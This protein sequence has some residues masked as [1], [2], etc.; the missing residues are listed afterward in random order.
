MGKLADGTP[1]P[2]ELPQGA[3]VGIVELLDCVDERKAPRSAFTRGPI[4]WLFQGAR[5]FEFPLKVSG[6]L[7]LWTEPTGRIVCDDVRQSSSVEAVAWDEVAEVQLGG[8]EAARLDGAIGVRGEVS[9]AQGGD[10]D[11]LPGGRWRQA[12]GRAVRFRSRMCGFG[13]VMPGA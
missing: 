3:I 12:S 6:Q 9:V 13:S 2:A 11:D 4:C 7:G 5:A 1:V 8:V 10:R